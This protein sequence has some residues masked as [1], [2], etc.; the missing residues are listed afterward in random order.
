MSDMPDK[1]PKNTKAVLYIN[2]R[3][4]NTNSDYQEMNKALSG[5]RFYQAF[6]WKEI[7]N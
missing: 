4:K 3:G 5:A 1:C 7:L 6:V 2:K